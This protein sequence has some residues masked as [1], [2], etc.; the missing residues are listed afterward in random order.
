MMTD[1]AVRIEEILLRYKNQHM[2]RTLRSQLYKEVAPFLSD[3]GDHIDRRMVV[4]SEQRKLQLI[5]KA[6]SPL[7]KLLID[8]LGEGAEEFQ[9]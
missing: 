9:K 5:L 7:G 3:L 1:Q 2:T 4:D 8:M 6:K